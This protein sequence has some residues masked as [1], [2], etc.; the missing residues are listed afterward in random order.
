MRQ[1]PLATS[2]L[3][4]SALSAQTDSFLYDGAWR[5][6]IVYTPGNWQPGDTVPLVLNL[7]GFGETAQQQEF[8]ALM[9]F[10]ADTANFIVVYPQGINN[11][12]DFTGFSVDDVGFIDA[13]IDNIHHDFAVDLDRVYACGISNGGFMTYALACALSHRIVAFASVAGSMSTFSTLTCNPGR[14]VPVFEIHGTADTLVPY[15]G[16]FGV[17]SAADLMA[18]WRSKNGCTPQ[19]DSFDF[20]DIFP[21]DQSTVTAFRWSDCDDDSK[22]WLYRVNNGGHTWPGTIPVPPLGPTNLDIYG[23]AEIWNFFRGFRFEQSQPSVVPPTATAH[24]SLHPN[25]A[26]DFVILRGTGLP[27]QIDVMTING[28]VVKSGS[29]SGVLSTG[30]LANGAYV[31]SISSAHALQRAILVVQH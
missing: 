23:S 10:V 30:D 5:S 11:T 3:L 15:E 29:S 14:A 18:F 28:E 20:P 27:V 4:A 8:Y 19:V 16:G 9:N 17:E 1:L 22:V 21:F 6:Y 25:P 24:V 12:W 26:N 31:V 7:H 2:L 13:L